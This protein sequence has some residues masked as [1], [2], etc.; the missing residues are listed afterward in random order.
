MHTAAAST[1]TA[2]PRAARPQSPPALQHAEAQARC[3][4]LIQER[5]A[6]GV[7]V[8][9]AGC[10]KT[11]LLRTLLREGGSLAHTPPLLIDMTAAGGRHLLAELAD[12]LGLQPVPAEPFALWRAIR[13][14]LEGDADCG[15][16]RVVLLDH[17]D[18]ARADVFLLLRGLLNTAAPRR[19]LTII[20]A[21]RPPLPLALRQLLADH[22]ALR[23]ELRCLASDETAE[24]ARA[25]WTQTT[26]AEAPLDPDALRT[27]HTLTAGQPRQLDRLCE[28]VRL[29]SAVEGT[30]AVTSEMIAA[31]FQELPPGVSERSA[32][33]SAGGK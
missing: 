11:R 4:F 3:E 16:G 8:G 17:L 33:A 15:Q 28:L 30:A 9:P 7:V 24:F 32:F 20:A 29:A 1:S 2:Q 26:P 31:A 19:A 14:R 5:K 23:I 27:L 18:T 22:G 25:V 6:F 13:D 12:G 21:A 10:G